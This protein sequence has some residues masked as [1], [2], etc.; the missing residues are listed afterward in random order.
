MSMI[1]WH[2]SP[3]KS[4]EIKKQ[5]IAAIF[6]IL[7]KSKKRFANRFFG[8]GETRR[9]KKI[10]APQNKKVPAVSLARTPKKS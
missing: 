10:D 9:I 7:P 1:F 5:T 8:D 4:V 6:L 2:F 3:K